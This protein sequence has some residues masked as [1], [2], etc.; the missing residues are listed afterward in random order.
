M[1]PK[2]QWMI[3][4]RSKR[5]EW[6]VPYAVGESR[7]AARKAW[8]DALYMGADDALNLF[9]RRIADGSIRYAKV[10]IREILEAAP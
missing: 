5:H 3:V 10:E 8:C 6:L 2:I 9:K 7:R 1:K 4:A